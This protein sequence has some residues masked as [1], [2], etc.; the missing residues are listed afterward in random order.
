MQNSTFCL[1]RYKYKGLKKLLLVMKLTTLIILI[2]FMYVSAATYGQRINI[3]AHDITIDKLFKELKKQTGYSFLYKSGILKDQPTINV[4]IT[5]ATITEVLDKFLKD[6]PLDYLIVDKNIVVRRKANAPVKENGPMLFIGKVLNEDKKPLPGVTIKIKGAQVGQ[7]YTNEKGEFSILAISEDAVLQFSYVGYESQELKVKGLKNPLSI[8]LKASLSN[9]DQVQVTAYGTTTKR[10]NTG[11]ITTVSGKEIAENPVPNVLQAL[12]GRVPGL[13]IQQMTGQ[14]ASPYSINI[15]GQNSLQSVSNGA[16]QPLIIV[17]GVQYPGGTLPL[18]TLGQNGSIVGSNALN[19]LDPQ[20]IASVDV[21]KDADATAIYGSRGAYGVILI[22]TKRGQPGEAKLT[23]NNYT[24]VSVRGTT[25]QLLSLQQY[26]DMRKEAFKNDGVTPGPNDLDV[27]GTWPADRNTDFQHVLTGTHAITSS[28]NA[29]FSG[30]AGNI[31]YLVGGNYNVQNNI[32]RNTG[33]NKAVGLNF[34]LNSTSK[35]G[36]FSITLVNSYSSTINTE[37]PVDFSF[38]SGGSTTSAPNAPSLT[39]PDGSLNWNDYPQNPLAEL[40]QIYKNV[41]N[42]LTSSTQLKYK[43]TA[44]LSLNASFNYN[45]LSGREQRIQP[46][47]FFNP[48]TTF[49]TTSDLNL[50]DQSTWTFEPNANY[51]RKLGVKGTLSVTAGATLQGYSGYNQE[52]S[53]NNF[54][55]DALLYD[56]TSSQRANIATFYNQTLRRYLGYFGII[57]YNWDNK[58]IIDLNGR[59]DGSSK[60]GVNNQFG[61]FGSV[62]AA[63]II[64]EEGWFK[65]GL[66]FI[67]FAKL[68]GSYGTVGG[69]GIPDYLTLNTYGKASS[70]E[71]SLGLAQTGLANPYLQWE[72]DLKKEIGLNLEFLKGAISFEGDYYDTRVSNQ[73]T[74]QFLS[75]VTGFSSITLNR[76]AV[77]HSYGFEFVLTTHNIKGKDFSWTTVINGTVPKSIL[78]SYPGL[79]TSGN[80]NLV[81]GKSVNGVRVYQYAGVN[82]QTGTYN[83]ITR[84]GAITDGSPFSGLPGL[85]QTLDKTQF[86]DLNPKFYGGITNSFRYKNFSLDVLI[87]VT[88]RE[89]RNS[90]GQE[91]FPPGLF[92]GVGFNPTTAVLKRWQKPGDIT[93]VAKFSQSIFSFFPYG[94]FQQSAGAYSNAMYA[95][96]QNLN[97]SYVFPASIAK[98]AGLSAL[99]IYVQGQNLFTVSKYGDLD[100]ENLGAGMAPLRIITGGITLTL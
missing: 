84:N 52:T 35:N 12:Q 80:I 81:I 53:G 64:S 66:P 41:T 63:W 32:E 93:N 77:I 87:T 10:L 74:P 38:L 65:K 28:T 33:N 54:I 9:L 48:N 75:S 97:L 70:Y 61:S 24:G 36:K 85:D 86:I 43:P 51:T 78:V 79:A 8:V 7:T 88:D 100:P 44:G 60:F 1:P 4:D 83:F 62:G 25:P 72:K 11:N 2:G 67:S 50:Y 23:V 22:I 90:L 20:S 26:L 56:P 71:T 49:Y 95:R 55:S 99:R 47:S 69:D 42:N 39:N 68:R 73:L 3:N 5:D 18:M 34:N 21:L 45:K 92:D 15:R 37:V 17:D 57:N 58:Y 16:N 98:K 30:G 13:F 76:D 40:N 94:T 82:P 96:L 6:R 31:S 46:S 89:G 29:T 59:R 19:Y 91:I 27:N 14:A